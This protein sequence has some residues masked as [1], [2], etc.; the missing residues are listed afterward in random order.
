MQL[1][2]DCQAENWCADAARALA[3]VNG[4]RTAREAQDQSRWQGRVAKA[5]ADTI[6]ELDPDD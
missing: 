2:R 1:W 3:E 4:V 5:V 6:I